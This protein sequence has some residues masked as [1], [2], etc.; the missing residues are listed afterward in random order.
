M[1]PRSRNRDREHCSAL[2]LS[3]FAMPMY[4]CIRGILP[5]ISR[6]FSHSE[7][8]PNHDVK[9]LGSYRTSHNI[10]NY[11]YGMFI[12]VIFDQTQFKTAMVIGARSSTVQSYIT[13]RI[14][15]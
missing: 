9:N 6:V 12:Y 1:I 14:N 15:E 10:F 13:E 7:K 11:S 3:H 4:F 8:A 5:V 2:S